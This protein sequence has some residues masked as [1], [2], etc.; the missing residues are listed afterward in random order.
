MCLLLAN[1]IDNFIEANEKVIDN[2]YIKLIIKEKDNKYII[3]YENTFVEKP[4][5]ND[6]KFIISKSAS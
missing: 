1:I 2:K 6:G 3:E 5:I 4:T